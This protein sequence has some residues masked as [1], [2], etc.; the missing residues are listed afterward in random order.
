MVLKRLEKGVFHK[1]RDKWMST[2]AYSNDLRRRSYHS[3]SR[4][5][6]SCY[7]SSHSRETTFTSKKHHNRRA[8]SQRTKALSKSERSA[9]GHWKPRPKRQKSIV[10]EDLSQPWKK[11]IKDPVK[12]HNIKQRDGESIKEF[13]RSR[14]E[15]K[16]QEGRLP[17]PTKAGA[18]ARQIHPPHKNT[19]RNSGFGQREVQASFANDNPGKKRNASKFCEFHKEVGHTTDDFMHLKR[20]SS[21]QNKRGHAPKR[22]KAIYEEIENLVDAGIIKEVHYHS[23]LSNPI[24]VKK[25]DGRWRMC[26]DF[27]DLNKACSK[28][29]YPLS[30][31]DWKVESLC[32]YPFKCFLDAY[33]GYHQMKMAKKDEEN[34]SFITSQGIF[35]YSKIPFR[36]GAT[37][38]RLVDMDFQK[39]IAQNLEVYVDDLVIRIYTKQEKDDPP[40]TPMEDKEELLDSWILFIDGSSCIDCSKAG[41][42]IISPKGMEFTYAL[43]FRF[44]AINNEAKDDALIAGLR[45]AEQIGVKNLQANVDSRLVTNE[46]NGT[47]VAKD[48]GMIKYL[49]KVK[50]LASTFKEFSIKQVPRGENKKADAL[51]KMAS[52]SFAHLSKEVLV[53]ELKEKLIDEKEEL[54]VVEEEGRTWMNR[55]YEY[56]T[57]EIIL[58]EKKKVDYI[59]RE[60]HEG[61]CGM[62]AGP[63]SVVA[64]ALR[65]CNGETPFSLTYGMEAVILV[66]IG[67]P[68]LRTA[69]VD[70]VK[71]DEALEINLDFLEEKKEH[72]QFGK[73]RVKPRWKSTIMLGFATQVLGLETLSTET[74]K[75]VMRNMEASSDLSSK[76]HMRSQK[77]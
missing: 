10:E 60:I 29:G 30:K 41:L 11:C 45:I 1:L 38:Q 62:H 74:I 51:S 72:V 65:S 5:T 9:E 3:S 19:K 77:H 37:Y 16:L 15:D 55:I 52:T 2:S 56:L 44:N 39:Q 63:R 53:G 69:K 49:E 40:D 22:N 14:I 36:S 50:N 66:E 18:K 23:W 57:E 48:P 31:I 4:D 8:P 68:T 64:K 43:R 17:E 70:M 24:M 20:K 61:S 34:T 47:Y 6:K 25:H 26:V 35:C 75:Q 67:M 33:K 28:D 13:L 42:I 12:I 73:Q 54:A 71:N 76:D 21:G 27:K 7:Q 32:G 58:E 59:L 46:V